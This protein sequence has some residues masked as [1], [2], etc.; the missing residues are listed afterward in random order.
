[1]SSWLPGHGSC[2]VTDSLCSWQ[3]SMEKEGG[4]R[5]ATPSL[6]L[7]TLAIYYKNFL[8]SGMSPK[9]EATEL[10]PNPLTPVLSAACQLLIYTRAWEWGVGGHGQH[11]PNL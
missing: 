5:E 1:M 9:W 4:G 3:M 11:P 10:P 8:L 2:Q 7:W 6:P